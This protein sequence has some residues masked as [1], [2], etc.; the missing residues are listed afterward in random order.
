MFKKQK[1]WLKEKLWQYDLVQFEKKSLG[2]TNFLQRKKE[3]EKIKVIDVGCGD[4]RF[5]K[6]LEQHFD[7]EVM[8]VDTIDYL[9]V[10]IPFKRYDGRTLPVANK[11][12]DVALCMAVIH[13]TDDP[14]ALI[15]ELHRS[16]KKV[17]LIEDYCSTTLGKIGLHLNDYFTNVVQ[18]SYKWWCGYH[19]GSVFH[20][21]WRLKFKTEVELKEIFKRNGITL[22][23]YHR[24]QQSWKGM[25]HGVYVLS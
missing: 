3:G 20:M 10:S 17:A 19:K 1:E 7:C 11:A 5:S 18:N 24:T 2:L 12:Y 16:A 13:H 14:E 23:H 4:G 25:S 21:Q 15:K 22:D 8:G 9:A 6:F